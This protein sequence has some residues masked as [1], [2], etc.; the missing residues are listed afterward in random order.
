MNE[1]FVTQAIEKDRYLK[2]LKLVDQF[3]TE[4]KQELTRL[5]NEFVAANREQFPNGVEADW[6]NGTFGKI[7]AFARIDL[8]MDRVKSDSDPQGLTLNLSTRW[9]E[10]D[11]YGHPDRDGALCVAS[12]KI[13]YASAEDHQQVVEATRESDW[14]AEPGRDVYS[15][16][17]GIFYIPIESAHDLTR[18]YER[19]NEH[20]SEYVELYGVPASTVN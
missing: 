20:F 6:N 8:E 7:L 2:A 17:P 11:E 10:A 5:G 9:L 12:Y 19:L 13:K 1:E 16:S 14:E 4:L 3:E 18:A 15:N